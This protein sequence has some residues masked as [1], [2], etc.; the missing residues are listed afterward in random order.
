M[1]GGCFGMMGGLWNLMGEPL[2]AVDGPRIADRG[3]LYIGPKSNETEKFL[4]ARNPCF[5]VTDLDFPF[6]YKGLIVSRSS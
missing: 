1:M 2:G 4:N 6:I 3:P 5:S